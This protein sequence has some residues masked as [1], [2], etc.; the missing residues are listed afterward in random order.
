MAGEERGSGKWARAHAIEPK[1]LEEL[2]NF[3]EAEGEI[4][5]WL[6][7]GTPAIEGVLGTV[8]VEGTKS[9]GRLIDRLYAFNSLRLRILVHPIGVPQIDGL[10]V[11]FE[12]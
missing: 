4:L 8:R 5:Y 3:L 10:L 2:G 6:T 9:G 12:H 7:H 11:E 1:E